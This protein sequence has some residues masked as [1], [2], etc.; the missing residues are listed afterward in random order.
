MAETSMLN[1]DSLHST[2]KYINSDSDQSFEDL[3][4]NELSDDNFD[5]NSDKSRVNLFDNAGE[6]DENSTISPNLKE[7]KNI[8]IDTSNNNHPRRKNSLASES[9][10]SYIN[11]NDFEHSSDADSANEIIKNELDFLNNLNNENDFDSENFLSDSTDEFED[12]EMDLEDLINEEL[13]DDQAD[14]PKINSNIDDLTES[15]TK[16]VNSAKTNV[17]ILQYI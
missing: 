15:L 12:V 9:S 2:N 11:N 10:T 6:A 5:L 1:K 8:N 16:D 13:K 4:G 17:K 7:S 3:F 14:S